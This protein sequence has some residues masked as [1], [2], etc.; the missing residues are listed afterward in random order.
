MTPTHEP[1]QRGQK[2]QWHRLL[3]KHLE[4]LLTPVGITVQ[5]EPQV[6]SEPPK[7]DILLLRR[8]GNV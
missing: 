4:L 3:G 5:T 2:T 6:M 1:P 8:E 7:V